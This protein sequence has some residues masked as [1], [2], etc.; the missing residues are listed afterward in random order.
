MLARSVLAI[1]GLSVLV[2]GVA[3]PSTRAQLPTYGLGRAPTA[4]EIKAWDVSR[5]MARGCR[6]AAGRPP[7]GS[8]SMAADAP[9]AMASGARTP[10]TTAW[11]GAA[12]A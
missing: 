5:L 4:E 12:A 8:R 1:F 7:R 3:A 6:R 2:S 10:S 11:S 9:R